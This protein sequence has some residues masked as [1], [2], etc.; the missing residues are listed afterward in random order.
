MLLDDSWQ[1][2]TPEDLLARFDSVRAALES[3]KYAV[4]N[5][6]EKF[7]ETISQV[8]TNRNALY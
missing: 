3:E 8:L 4:F 1:H 6:D 2:L 5:D 7:K